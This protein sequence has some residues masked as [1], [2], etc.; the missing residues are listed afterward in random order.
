MEKEFLHYTEALELKK[1]G[2]NEPCLAKYCRYNPND[3][4]ELFPQSQNFFKGYFEYCYNQ[5]YRKVET[6]AAPLFQQ[7]FDWFRKKYKF[8]IEI[9]KGG[10]PK[11]Y[12]VFVD[13]YIYKHGDVELFKYEDAKLE[14]LRLL[15]KKA[16]NLVIVK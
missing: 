9:S 8:D 4:I 10:K 12:M 15:I 6:V 5:E 14:G 2:F 13:S 7:A 11:K 1:L 3:N 16:N